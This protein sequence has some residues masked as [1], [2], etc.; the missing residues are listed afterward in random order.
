MTGELAGV[1]PFP[2]FGIGMAVTIRLVA[3]GAC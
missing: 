1:D 2:T 3:C